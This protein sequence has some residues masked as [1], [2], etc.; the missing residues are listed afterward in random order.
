MTAVAS[1][2]E[3]Y[4]EV[5]SRVAEHAARAGRKPDEVILV[6]V[7]K[8]AE[9]EHIRTLIELGHRDFGENRVQQLTQRAALLE[10]Y[11]ERK[12]VLA[13]T[14][15]AHHPD[16]PDAL[17]ELADVRWHMIGHLQRNKA[18]KAAEI[19]RLIHSVDS[20]RVAEELQAYGLKKDHD[21]EI[22][23]QANCS[24]EEQKAGCPIPAARALAEQIDSM[25]HVRLRGVMTMAALSDDPE[26]ARPTFARA[27]DLFEDIRKIGVGDGR[28]NLISMGMSGD[29]TVALEEGANV[30]RVGTAIFGEAPPED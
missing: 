6:A 11:F 21:I 20:L 1:I 25:G 5:R 15:E 12:R 27:R 10:E 14:R 13:H 8:A 26:D 28:F 29:Y 22:L 4:T 9:P 7:T 19:C 16:P 24:G 30:V 3:R 2:E 17:G 18:R 23:L